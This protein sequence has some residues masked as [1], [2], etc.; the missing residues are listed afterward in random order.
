MKPSDAL[1]VCPI[2]GKVPLFGGISELEISEMLDCLGSRLVHYDRDNIIFLAGDRVSSVGIITDGSVRVVREDIFGN[3]AILAKLFAGELF[4]ETFACAKVDRLPVS[5]IAASDCEV[6]LIDY[7]R[8][9]MRCHSSCVFHGRLIENM[10]GIL[11]EKNLMLNQK[12]EALSARTTRGKLLAFLASQAQI[13]GS[14]AFCIPFDRQELADFL[15]V[16]RS[17]MSAELG[18]MRAEGLIH[19]H[20]NYFELSAP[21]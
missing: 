16:D 18:R 20:K 13:A 21:K 10:L 2:L 15:S 12:I 6:L 17:A 5:V 4:G 1:R 3:R 7:R 14:N 9:V 19:F 11:A 8:I